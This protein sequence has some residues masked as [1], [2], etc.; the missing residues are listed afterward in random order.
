MAITASAFQLVMEIIKFWHLRV[1][2]QL[3]LNDD[4]TRLSILQYVSK[5]V[6]KPELQLRGSLHTHIPIRYVI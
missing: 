6:C 4:P 1:D 5:Y 3:A 2:G